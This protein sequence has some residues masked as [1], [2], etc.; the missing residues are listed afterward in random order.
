MS[1]LLFKHSRY[2]Y[3]R[4]RDVMPMERKSNST[5]YLIRLD[6]VVQHPIPFGFTFD[7]GT[8]LKRLVP[9]TLLITFVDGVLKPIYLQ[10]PLCEAELSGKE[11][12]EK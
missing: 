2:I 7:K 12:A 8:L 4:L 1:V 11:L 9:T 5:E 6:P 3:D 10:S